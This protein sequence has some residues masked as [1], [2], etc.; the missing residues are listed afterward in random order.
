[1]PS[2]N[3]S[4]YGVKNNYLKKE[5]AYTFIIQEYMTVLFQVPCPLVVIASR[6]GIS[7]RLNAGI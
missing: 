2:Y 5:N 1:M 4:N 6:T 7:H 3:C